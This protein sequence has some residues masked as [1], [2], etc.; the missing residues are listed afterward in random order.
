MLVILNLFRIYNFLTVDFKL[1]K[2]KTELV[3]EAAVFL[4]NEIRKNLARPVLFLS[5]GGSSLSLLPFIETDIFKPNLTVGMLDERFSTDPAVNN[6]SQL[7]NTDFYKKAKAQD[8]HFINE[9]ISEHER[10]QNVGERFDAALKAWKET[11]A[12]GFSIATV[13]IGPDGHVSGIL[14][15]PEDMVTFKS[16]FE[17]QSKWAV[18]YDAVNKTHYNE[19]ITVTFTFMRTV[20]DEAIVFMTGEDKKEAF[21]RIYRE[22]GFLHQTPARIIRELKHVTVFTD[23]T[24]TR[25]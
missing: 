12:N 23:I 24:D 8:V 2:N 22:T 20:L 7:Q 6:F 4:S 25:E 18:G 9:T 3:K 16:L 15:Y 14:P 10:L 1:N 21:A 11:H 5:S 17:D 19:R 13:G